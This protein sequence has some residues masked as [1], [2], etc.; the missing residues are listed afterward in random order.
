M[1]VKNK[2]SASGQWDLLMHI[3]IV[4]RQYLLLTKVYFLNEWAM[5]VRL[6]TRVVEASK[7]AQILILALCVILQEWNSLISAW[8]SIMTIN[9]VTIFWSILKIWKITNVKSPKLTKIL[10]RL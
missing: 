9:F 6:V 2:L 5:T 1:S 10:L 8:V 7:L 3:G 4:P